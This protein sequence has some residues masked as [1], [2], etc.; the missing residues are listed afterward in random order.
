MDLSGRVAAITGASSGI[1][2]A[3]ARH[4]AREGVA[5][6]LGARRA[7]RL[8]EAVI[9][10]HP[11]LVVIAYGMNDMRSGMPVAA[12]CAELEGLITRIRQTLDP[13]I[14]LVNPYHMTLYHYYPPFDRG[15]VEAGL[16]RR[17][18]DVIE[19][20]IVH[21]PTGRL[22]RPWLTAEDNQPVGPWKRL[23]DEDGVDDHRQR[24]EGRNTC[25]RQGPHR[26]RGE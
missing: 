13:L 21:R 3:V 20:Q 16:G 24:D 19:M 14:V 22:S 4:L 5:V 18:R 6:T 17:K 7:E 15:N 8:D 10:H 2:L 26:Q 1:G 12:F 9:A 11:D 25:R 23:L